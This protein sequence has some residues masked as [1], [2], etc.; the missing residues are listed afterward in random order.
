[1]SY[2]NKKI[3]ALS[4]Y[5]LIQQLFSESNAGKV[6]YYT[7]RIKH[8]RGRHR[9]LRGIYCGLYMDYGYTG[10][11]HGIYCEEREIGHKVL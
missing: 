5:L 11:L 7:L 1:M 6:L 4:A 10:F 2:L 9:F 8:W 3:I